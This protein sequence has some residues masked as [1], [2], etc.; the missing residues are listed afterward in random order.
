MS[1]QSSEHHQPIQTTRLAPSPTGALHLGNARTFLVNWAMARARGWRV[2]M[3]IEDLDGPRIKPGAAD[4]LLRTLEWLGLDWDGPAHTQS[5]DLEPCREA[6]RTL[7]EQAL[8][9]PCRLTRRQIEEAAD[10]PH[11]RPESSRPGAQYPIELRPELRPRRFDDPHTNWRLAAPDEEVAFEDA[12][13]GRRSF[14]VLRETGDFVIWTKRAQPA[15]QL[16][17]VVDDHR[18]GVTQ[19]VRGDDLLPSTARQ[20]LL[21]RAL[22]LSPQ[23]TYTHLPLVMG[24][25]GRRLAKRHGDTRLLR[26]RREGVRPE[27]IVGLLAWWSGVAQ[28]RCEM[29][30]EAFARGLR[31]DTIPK[32]ERVFAQED[33]AWLRGTT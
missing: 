24:E 16:A 18:F 30:A 10:A 7:A 21:H 14:H 4:E 32:T 29:T 1:S 17:V 5:D 28:E 9:Y 22:G 6:M 33:D 26:Y 8:A 19:V 23:P 27:R 3:R 20:I 31:L 15:Y 25:D 12:F 2:L 11:E 13:A